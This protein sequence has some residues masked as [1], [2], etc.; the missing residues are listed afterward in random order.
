MRSLLFV[1]LLALG[2]SVTLRAADFNYQVVSQG[3][4]AVLLVRALNLDAGQELNSYQDF[5]TLLSANKVA[6]KDGWQVE[7]KLTYAAYVGTIGLALIQYNKKDTKA[8]NAGLNSFLSFLDEK[9]GIS[10]DQL[11]IA[12]ASV[13]GLGELNSGIDQYLATRTTGQQNVSG[14]QTNPTGNTGT[15]EKIKGGVTS[16]VSLA[17]ASIASLAD[18]MALITANPTTPPADPTDNYWDVFSRPASPILPAQN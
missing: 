4:W 7:K 11:K 1:S 2:L 14:N 5:T 9:I 15:V 10:V 18:A 8:N 17:A 16:N 13:P 12:L 3:D 6:P